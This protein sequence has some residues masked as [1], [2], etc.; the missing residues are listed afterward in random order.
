MEVKFLEQLDQLIQE[1]Y[2]SLSFSDLECIFGIKLWGVSD[3]YVEKALDELSDNWNNV[4]LY[5]RELKIEL[6]LEYY[7]NN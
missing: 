5:P 2:C 3:E 6:F 4:E 7:R 1:W